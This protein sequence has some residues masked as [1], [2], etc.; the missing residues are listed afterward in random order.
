MSRDHTSQRELASEKQKAHSLRTLTYEFDLL[1]E[2]MVNDLK[3]G[4]AF[5]RD[6]YSRK[7][8]SFDKK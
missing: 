4:I 7:T 2:R 3:S 5:L 8:V 1:Y 6:S